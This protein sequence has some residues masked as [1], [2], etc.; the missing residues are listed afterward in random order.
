MGNMKGK[1]DID[2]ARDIT[3][4]LKATGIKEEETLDKIPDLYAKLK[5][6]KAIAETEGMSAATVGLLSNLA[7]SAIAQGKIN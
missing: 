2:V 4:L 1:D 7:E 5:E 6:M 3:L